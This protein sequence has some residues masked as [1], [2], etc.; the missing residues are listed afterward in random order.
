MRSVL[1]LIVCAFFSL[2]AC[3]PNQSILQSNVDNTA[4]APA[5]TETVPPIKKITVGELMNRT[6]SA[7]EGSFTFPCDLQTYK[8]EDRDKLRKLRDVW[9]SKE[10]DENYELR[11]SGD[12]V[13]PGICVLKVEDTTKPA[14]NNWGLI[15]IK[16]LDSNTYQW[17][18][19]DIDLTNARLTWTSSVPDIV[20]S[21]SNG[22]DL[23]T[24]AV[25]LKGAK[26]QMNCRSA[27]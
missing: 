6:A 26:Y 4:P 14:P 10:K 11:P 18:A 22:K 13:C 1:L 15:V 24:C 25:E 12:C 17:L 5:P 27:K 20:F 23:K 16:D 19:K 8:P 2:S 9:M 7:P 3:A 21:D